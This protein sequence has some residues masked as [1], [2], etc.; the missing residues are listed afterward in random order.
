METPDFLYGITID[1]AELSIKTSNA[2]KAAGWENLGDVYDMTYDGVFRVKNIG[3]RGAHEVWEVIM[4]M[5][6]ARP[7]VQDIV[8]TVTIPA[9]TVGPNDT[10][11]VSYDEIHGLKWRVE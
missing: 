6:R 9:G 10:I 1:E 2:L 5:I 4:G 3:R 7:D 11:V 8:A